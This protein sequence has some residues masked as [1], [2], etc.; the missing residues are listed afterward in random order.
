VESANPTRR[1]ANRRVVTPEFVTLLAG[2]LDLGA[3]VYC[4]SDVRPLATEM[5][6]LF[7]MN[8]A[9]RLDQEAYAS[10]GEMREEGD[11]VVDNQSAVRAVR[12]GAGTPGEGGAG[13]GGGGGE[14]RGGDIER[15]DASG[16]GRV[17]VENS[18]RGDAESGGGGSGGDNGG[19]GGAGEGGAGAGFEHVFPAHQYQWHE[20][21][22]DDEGDGIFIRGAAKPRWLAANPYTVPTERDLVCESKWRPVYRFVV[23]RL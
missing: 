11:V 8:P 2:T 5:Q 19:E 4:C 10:H 3:R 12:V 9:F 7:L 15:T 1:H 14:G 23:H 18:G 22:G 16:G 20:G 13:G 6:A 21:E 17:V